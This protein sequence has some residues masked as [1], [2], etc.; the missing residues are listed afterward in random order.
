MKFQN[1]RGETKKNAQADLLREKEQ[2]S[3]MLF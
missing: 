3:S 2:R 1:G